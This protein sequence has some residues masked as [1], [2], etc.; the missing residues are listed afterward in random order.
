[1]WK[2]KS[3]F[4]FTLSKYKEIKL[5]NIW[6]KI[7]LFGSFDFHVSTKVQVFYSSSILTSQGLSSGKNLDNISAILT[8]WASFTNYILWNISLFWQF[9]RLWSDQLAANLTNLVSEK[10]ITNFCVV[11]QIVFTKPWS[12]ICICN[13]NFMVFISI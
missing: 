6:V 4:K 5:L 1:M 12:A 8:S 9:A 2:F 3:S 7:F 11:H 13:S 10:I